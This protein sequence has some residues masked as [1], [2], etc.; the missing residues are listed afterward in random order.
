VREEGRVGRLKTTTIAID[1]A[2]GGT[3]DGKEGHATSGRT[4]QTDKVHTSSPGSRKP[5]VPN[6]GVQA[7]NEVW[8][9]LE[10]KAA[11]RPRDRTRSNSKHSRPLLE[12]N[13]PDHTDEALPSRNAG[14]ALWSE[15]GEG[16]GGER[17][18][19]NKPRDE[20]CNHREKW[21]LGNDHHK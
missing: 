15:E 16:K 9:M 18:E 4:P 21:H 17:E 3:G 12:R 10:H 6:P 11:P 14:R 2:G 8:C 5:S 1:R 13:L 20:G 7:T 19:R